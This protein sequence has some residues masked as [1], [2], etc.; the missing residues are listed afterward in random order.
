MAQVVNTRR[1]YEDMLASERAASLKFKGENGILKKK[2]GTV[3]EGWGRVG[4]GIM[5]SPFVGVAS[6]PFS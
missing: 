6:V 5:K 3:S 4:C 2:F 1:G